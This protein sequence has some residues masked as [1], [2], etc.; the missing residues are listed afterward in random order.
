MPRIDDLFDQLHGTSMYSKINLSVHGNVNGVFH[1]YLDKF[2]VVFIDDILVY[3]CSTDEHA[4]NL[5][6]ILDDLGIL[7][8]TT[9]VLALPSGL[10]GYVVYTDE[11]LQGLGCVLTYSGHVIFYASRQLKNHKENYKVHDLELAAIVSALKI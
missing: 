11:S 1:N 10:G 5:R 8:T 2:V 7:L 9:T 3:T 6:L 4:Q